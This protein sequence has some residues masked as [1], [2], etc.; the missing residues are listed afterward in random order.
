MINMARVVTK[1]EI[2]SSEKMLPLTKPITV[3]ARMPQTMPAGPSQTMPSTAMYMLKPR[4][5][6]TEMSIEP[7]VTTINWA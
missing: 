7:V 6:P 3:A 2:F 1:E 4:L 5:E